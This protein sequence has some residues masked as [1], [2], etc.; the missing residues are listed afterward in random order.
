MNRITATI[1][2]R[3]PGAS[4]II[5]F[6]S[7]VAGTADAFSDYDVLVLLPGGLDLDERIRVQEEMQAAFPKVDLDL[8]IGSER[9]LL[10]GLRVE[11]YYRFW[12]E[13]GIATFGRIP[14]M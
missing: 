12:L 8:L 6:G 11:A 14:R 13:N 4:A 5:F 10:G 9:W 2:A 3:L 7:R 1:R